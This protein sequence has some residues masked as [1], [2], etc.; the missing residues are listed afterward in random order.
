MSPAAYIGFGSNMGDREAK[1]AEVLEALGNLPKT[2]VQK[3]SRLYETEPVG[4][5]DGGPKFLNAAVVVQTDLGPGELM[6]RIRDIE[7]RLGKS[8]S[9][10]SDL[11]RVVDLDLLLYGTE[12]LDNGDVQVPHPRM[13]LRTFVLVPLAE[14]APYVVHPLFQCDAEELLGRLPVEEREQVRPWQRVFP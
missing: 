5:I 11:S 10:R 3:A 9:H 2:V 14:I 1:F 6:S 13:H 4:L 7:V 12:R 8:P